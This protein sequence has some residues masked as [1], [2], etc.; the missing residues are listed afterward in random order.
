MGRNVDCASRNT[1]LA[2]ALLV[3]GLCCGPL[4]ARAEASAAGCERVVQPD[5]TVTCEDAHG[6]VVDAAGQRVRVAAGDAALAVAPARTPRAADASRAAALV[7][8]APGQSIQAAI[9][10]AVDGDRIVVQPGIYVENLHFQGKAITLESAEG[11]A[12]TVLDGGNAGTVVTFDGGESREAVLRGF[13]ITRGSADFDGGGILIQGAS[14][15]ITGNVV[16]GN[17]AIDGAG[18]ATNFAS[19]LVQ[20]NRI[21]ANRATGGGGGLSLGGDSTPEILDNEISD[22]DASTGGGLELFAAGTPL[23]QGNVIRR[24]SASSLS[25]F[26]PGGGAISMFNRSDAQIVGNLIVDNSARNGGGVAWLVP[27]GARG[28]FLLNNTIAGNDGTMGSAIFADGFDRDALLVNNLL[29]AL[30]AQGAVFCDSFNDQNPPTFRFNDVHSRLGFAFGGTCSDAQIGMA[31]NI[32]V[33]PRFADAALG[34]YAL[35]A[36][37]PAI[38]AGDPLTLAAALPPSDLAGAP[39]I[40]D[41]DGDGLAVVDL[42]AYE[43]AIL[44]VGV[45]IEPGS[46]ANVVRVD[47][48]RPVAVAVL[49][50]ASFD[51]RN[52]DLATLHFGPARAPAGPR[53]RS[54]DVNR[55]GFIDLMLSF[56]VG[57]TGIQTDDT[58]ACLRGATTDAVPFEGCDR[59]QTIRSVPPLD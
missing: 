6:T 35:A 39:R 54:R 38:D 11:P 59:I 37:S 23:I 45:D 27:S 48:T 26:S 24:N 40:G 53:F 18:I 16:T 46:P 22:N 52:V 17:R 55:D 58:E 29:V 36:D 19:P 21:T 57:D 49:G 47:G 10:A 2:R 4:S 43:L 28:P 44:R 1:G 7:V 8:V 12:D 34:N 3:A 9:D 56:A 32:S 31:G 42:G 51:I 20:G 13:T 15:V 25:F 41:G 50:S 14:P 5:L 33:A 30:N